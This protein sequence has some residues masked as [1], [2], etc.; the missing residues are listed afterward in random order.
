MRPIVTTCFALFALAAAPG[1]QAGAQVSLE[2]LRAHTAFLADDLL[3]GRGTGT[4]GYAIAA[5]YVATMFQLSGIQPGTAEGTYFQHVPLRHASVDPS[6]ASF[7]TVREGTSGTLRYGED[8]Y[9][10]PNFWHE[11]SRV[12]GGLA[13]VGYGVSA[14]ERGYDDYAGMNVAGKLVV[15]IAGAPTAFPSDA[16]AHYSSGAVK[17][18]TAASRGAVGIVTVWTGATAAAFPWSTLGRFLRRGS[19][20]WLGPSGEPSSP[21]EAIGATVIVTADAA[22][23]LLAGGPVPLDE[24]LTRL[25]SGEPASFE[26]P[27]TATITVI[28]R[29]RA[30][31]SPNVVGLLRGRDPVLRDEYVVYTAH[32]DHEGIGEPAGGD[33]I[34]NGALDNAAAAASLMEVARIFASAESPPARSILFV[35]TTAEEEGLLGAE[36]FAAFPPVPAAQIVAD[37]NMDGNHML[38]P[39]RDIIAFGDQHS[40][41]G[42]IVADAAGEVGLEVSPDPM[43]EQN[44]FVRSDHYPFVKRGIPSLFL[45]N[46]FNSSDDTIDGLATVQQWLGTVYHTPK[47]DLDQFFYWESGVAYTRVAYLTGLKVA[48]GPSRPHWNPGDFFGERGLIND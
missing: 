5:N 27:T 38:F 34:Y 26:A 15:T 33:S 45:V 11:R 1:Q 42:P 18:E 21:P 25:E 23:Q 14:S 13:F 20:R 16:A 40:T 28:S 2:R 7:A 35:G 36:Y 6:G 10:A 8:Y 46:G 12:S 32:L 22:R 29:H 3:E 31:S 48:N 39:V 19:M 17:A 4:R 43:P 41:L 47:D 9:A 44:F 37:I 30:L 24:A